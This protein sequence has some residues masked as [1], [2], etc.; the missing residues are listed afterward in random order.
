[1]NNMTLGQI[2]QSINE[3]LRKLGINLD[4]KNDF[5]E[6]SQNLRFFMRY[7]DNEKKDKV[8]LDVLYTRLGE[9][10]Q[11]VTEIELAKRYMFVWNTTGKMIHAYKKD[12]SRSVAG[13]LCGNE[14][15]FHTLDY[16]SID[17]RLYDKNREVLAKTY[18][19]KCAKITKLLDAIKANEDLA[20]KW[21]REEREERL[22][23]DDYNNTKSMWEDVGRQIYDGIVEMLYEIVERASKGLVEDVPVIPLDVVAD[24]MRKDTIKDSWGREVT[25]RIRR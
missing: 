12:E 21:S 4:W 24:L 20:E 6:S 14:R 16:V 3:S 18:C 1:M 2:D 11:M 8:A 13:M 23:V 25:V 7:W 15:L 5:H 9:R 17:R 10:K 19:S 22:T